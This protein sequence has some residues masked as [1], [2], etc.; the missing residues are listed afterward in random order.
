MAFLK[1]IG[2]AIGNLTDKINGTV[3]PDADETPETPS[4]GRNVPASE[5]KPKRNAKEPGQIFNNAIDNRD[6]AIGY[7]LEEFKEATGTDSQSLRSLFIY[8]IVDRPDYNVKDYAWADETMKEQLRLRLDN[9]ML[10]NIGS[11]VLDIRMVTKDELPDNARR[12]VNDVLYYSFL[13]APKRADRVRA[14]ISVVTGTGSLASEIYELDSDRKKVYH[15]GRGQ[16]ANKPGAYRPNDIVVRDNDR[17]PAI[18]EC[19]N[20]VS[21]AHADIIAGNGRF[22]F[23]ALKWGC[24]PMGGSCSKLIYDGEEHEVMDT[25][26]RHP[27]ADGYMIELGKNVILIYNE[28]TD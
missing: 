19:N 20:H 5:E 4:S 23:K 24:R 21:S 3:S 7:I 18:Q 15:I 14:T 9:A 13:S 1:K 8:V 26:L 28:I 16:M 11:K 17:D 6:Q 22:Y 12:I 25:M 2:K 27:L 10:D